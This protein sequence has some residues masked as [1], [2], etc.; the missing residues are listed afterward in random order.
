[1]TTAD[2]AGMLR[3]HQTLA[4]RLTNAEVAAWHNQSVLRFSQADEAFSLLVI[5]DGLLAFLCT[6]FVRHAVD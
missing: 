5:F 3:L 1:M 4:A 2:R 6:I